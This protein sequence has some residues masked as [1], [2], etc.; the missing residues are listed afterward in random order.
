MHGFATVLSKCSQLLLRGH[1]YRLDLIS[2][3]CIAAKEH[4]FM[5]ELTR[6]QHNCYVF[7]GDALIFLKNSIVVLR[8]CA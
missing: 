2:T 3:I 4:K 7:F 6:D 5:F 1:T 8:L